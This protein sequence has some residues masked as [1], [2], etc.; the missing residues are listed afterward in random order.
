MTYEF[1]KKVY[2]DGFWYLAGMYNNIT[3]E[4]VITADGAIKILFLL[5][6]SFGLL[7][8]ARQHGLTA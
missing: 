1:Y 7:Q 4:L 8:Y 3:T 6:N 5:K 2:R